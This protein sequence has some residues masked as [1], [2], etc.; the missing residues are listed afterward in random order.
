MSKRLKVAAAGEAG[1]FVGVLVVELFAI[2]NA[3]R[4]ISRTLRLVNVGVRAIEKQAE[5]LDDQ[6]D[7]INRNLDRAANLLHDAVERGAVRG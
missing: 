6:I 4:Q 1:L 3:L 7:D 5:P 2:A